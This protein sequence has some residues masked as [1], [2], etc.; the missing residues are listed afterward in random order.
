MTITSRIMVKIKRRIRTS[1]TLPLQLKMNSIAVS[2]S[3][4][5]LPKEVADV[6]TQLRP[7]KTSATV[8]GYLH[9]GNSFPLASPRRHTASCIYLQLSILGDWLYIT[10]VNLLLHNC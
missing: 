5:Q 7:P 1:L 6:P 8:D 4:I 9:D 2:R 3:V 10:T